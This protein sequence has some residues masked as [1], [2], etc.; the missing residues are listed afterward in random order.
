ME[1]SNG[2]HILLV[3]D[4]PTTRRLFGSLL[5]RAGFEVLYAKD[6]NEGREMA[7]RFLPDL[8]LLDYNMPVMDGME[9]AQRLKHEPGSPNVNTPIAFLTN[10]DISIEAQKMLKEIGVEDYIQKG[11][12]NKEFIERVKKILGMPLE[13]IKVE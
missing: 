9:V 6:G 4:D 10:E 12:D 8:V 11:V 7:R 2:K 5:G 13:T 1:T 3:D